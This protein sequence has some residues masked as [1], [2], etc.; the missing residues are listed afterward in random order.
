MCPPYIRKDMSKQFLLLPRGE[1]VLHYWVTFIVITQ[2]GISH[3]ILLR[4]TNVSNKHCTENQNT[5]YTLT[6]L[7]KYLFYEIMW[8][9]FVQPAGHRWR[10]PISLCTPKAKNTHWEYVTL[11]G[12]PLQRWLQAGRLNCTYIACVVGYT[13]GRSILDWTYL[14]TGYSDH[15]KE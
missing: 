8:E 4:M 14:V 5:F 13:V 12:F 6:F 7:R 3:S 11:I 1:Y 10:M 9:R 2:T 15:A